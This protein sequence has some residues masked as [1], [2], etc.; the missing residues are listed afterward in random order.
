MYENQLRYKGVTSRYKATDSISDSAL[1]PP[2]RGHCGIYSTI[3]TT[4]VDA[5]VQP[6]TDD[7][8]KQITQQRHVSRPR[9]WSV[10]AV[11]EL[12]PVVRVQL[13]T[14]SWALVVPATENAFLY[15]FLLQDASDGSNFDDL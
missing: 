6:S 14:E 7:D 3:T 2:G 13:N 11:H 12:C 9:S 10:D 15:I 8:K 1:V 4:L 5:L